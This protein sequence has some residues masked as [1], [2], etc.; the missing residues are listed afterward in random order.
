MT[1]KKTI[2]LEHALYLLA[3]CLALAFR[4]IAL[5]ALPFNE[6]EAD[7]AWQAYQV[8]QAQPIQI[9]SQPAYVL[10]TSV[11]FFFFTS[12]EAL[13][14]A[15]PALAG[16]M[17]V[18]LPFVLK[19]KLG[20]KAALVAAFGLALDP[21]MVA[22][23]RQAGSPM[24]AIG[25]AVLA[26]AAWKLAKPGTAGVFAAL[27]LLSGQPAVFGVLSIAVVLLLIVVSGS[28]QTSLE[29]SPPDRKSFLIAAGVTLLAVGTLG[30][31]YPLGLSA[32]VQAVPDYFSGWIIARGFWGQVPWLQVFLAIPIYQPLA[33]LFGVIAL[34]QKKSW[35]HSTKRF[36]CVF[37]IVFFVLIILN[38][39]RLVSDLVWALL[40]LWLLVGPVLAPYL[41]LNENQFKNIVWAQAVIIL[42]LLSFWWANIVK[43]SRIY[44]V[45]IPQN[46]KL[47][48]LATLDYSTKEYLS[49]MVVVVVVPFV[50]VVMVT[51]VLTA[52]SKRT[53]LSGAVWGAGGFVALYTIGVLFGINDL[54]PQQANELWN[55][56]MASGYADDLRDALAELSE[57]STGT[58]FELETVYQ[59][60]SP[61]LH[62]Q[63]RDMPNARYAPVLSAADSPAV[64]INTT[65][66]PDEL[67]RP[68]AYR[69]EKIALQLYRSWGDRAFPLDFDRW[70]IYREAPLEKQW[71]VLWAREDIFVGYQELPDE[72]DLEVVEPVD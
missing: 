63:L 14:R 67:E 22:V 47:N 21:M 71:V 56:V 17:V 66:T 48:Q 54:R 19:E 1:E 7:W 58:R 72:I 32:M 13:A 41:S 46:F 53:A 5:G 57:P 3:F 28:K 61:L 44:F 64:I 37:V 4:L 9:G 39:S 18:V 68:S 45:N 12:S 27:F 51:V 16:S 52:W 11:L 29:I 59:V 43:I 70:F 42:V 30:M 33:L 25:F 15:L 62:W 34:L 50:I 38:P 24:L 69:G 60:D 6:T 8:S 10:L 26:F 40:P 31:R 23:S 49:R 2:T 35:D 55:P 20:Q 36:I 65:L